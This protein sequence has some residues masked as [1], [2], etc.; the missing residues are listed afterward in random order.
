MAAGWTPR[1]VERRVE[2]GVWRRVVGRAYTAEPEPDRA[3]RR[4]WAA[5][6][7][8]SDA[9]VGLH[10]AGSLHGFPIVLPESTDGIAPVHAY[11]AGARRPCHGLHAV[12][13]PLTTDD[14]A[15]F[16][17]LLLTTPQRT[18]VDLMAALP[19]SRALDLFAWVSSRH[20]LDREGLRWF[21]QRRRCSHGTPQ[22][23][24]L[25]DYTRDGAVSPGEHL[26]H[27]L[28]RGAGVRGWTSGVTITGPNGVIAVV[29][30]LFEAARVVIEI[31]GWRSHSGRA[32][33]QRDRQ[34]QNQLV[35]LGYKV[36][37]FTWADLVERPDSV[38]DQVR[39]LVSRFTGPR[40]L[41]R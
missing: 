14:I 30:V 10:T 38:V 4:A 12:R 7:T 25:L 36:L 23:S 17:G 1:Q 21:A 31:D 8:W 22:L 15:V 3:W 20:V 33:F 40:R 24:R 6:L 9:V 41:G 28:M 32:A 35:A 2:R 37:R 5:A 13:R 16:D 34:R 11:T 26:F 29:D 19:W 39:R 18:A 27:D